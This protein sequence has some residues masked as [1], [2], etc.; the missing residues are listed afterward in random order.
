MRA[1][2]LAAGSALLA[3]ALAGCGGGSSA[4]KATLDVIAGSE[5]KDVEPILADAERATGVHVTMTYSGTIAGI[6]R[7]AGGEKHDA[8]WFAQDK[9]LALSSAG[10]NVRTRTRIMLSPV[11]VGVKHS[12]AQ[13]LGWTGGKRV[14]WRDVQGAV[15]RGQFRYAMTNPTTSNSGF[16]AVL[17][18]STA[19][20]GTGDALRPS[21]VNQNA[22]AAFYRGQKIV[23]GSSGWLSDAYLNA[24]DTVDGII[25][26]EA[27]IAALDADP[28]LREK[29]DRI[30]P[31]D[32]VVTADY[33]LDLLDE[34]KKDAY[35]RLVAYLKSPDVQKR[36]A[37]TTYRRPVDTS[38][39][40]TQYP[41]ILQETSFPASASSVQQLLL[42]FL[43]QDRV[44]AHS[45]YV[46]DKTGSMQETDGTGK[47]RI[48]RVRDALYVLAG[49]DDSL[50]GQ[51]ARFADREKV[52]IL[53]FSKSVEIDQTFDMKR[54][55]DPNV[56]G[57]VRK[58]ADSLQPDG[59]TAIYTALE[60]ALAEAVRDE[61]SDAGR[62]ASIV[63]MTDGENNE[64][65]GY[66]QF[67]RKWQALPE[68]G[69][70]IH[71]FPIFIGE[72]NPKELK[73]IAD[74]TGGR[75]FDGRSQSLAEIFKE[76]RGY[77]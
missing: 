40:V 76:I 16:S 38:V 5:V 34:T 47:S 55:N 10:K 42:K 57:G 1:R 52:T 8:A 62:Y 68:Y 11:I 61:P 31:D 28:S 29:L 6:D 24:Q 37:Q 74:L 70:R 43:N 19:L 32:G 45:F 58:L 4:P 23:S 54:P 22:I 60:T 72:A 21:E 67:A 56:Y 39:A 44:P 65:D 46:L 12:V 59:N 7:L 18:V 26:Y 15:A 48:E 9:Y 41:P 66:D 50:T 69:R 30:Y 49:G 75:E 36:I 53:T 77:Q 73:R 17:S 20:A 3:L 33:P 25:T 51:F 27:S 2:L 35:D 13:R 64:G 71:I 14:G 63:L